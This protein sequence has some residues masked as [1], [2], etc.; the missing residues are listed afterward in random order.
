MRKSVLDKEEKSSILVV[1]IMK[2]FTGTYYFN[3][4]WYWFSTRNSMSRW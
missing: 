3:Y 1:Q 4:F 2:N